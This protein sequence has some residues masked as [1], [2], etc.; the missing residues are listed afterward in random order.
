VMHSLGEVFVKDEAEDV[1]AKFI[2]SH[3]A[4]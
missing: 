2:G 4:A 1:V 3:F